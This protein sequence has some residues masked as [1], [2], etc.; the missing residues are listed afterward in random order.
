MTPNIEAAIIGLPSPG[1]VTGF[2][3]MPTSALAAFTRIPVR[4]VFSPAMSTT[5][6]IIVTSTGPKYLAVSPDAAVETISLGTPI[7]SRCIA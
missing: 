2:V 7:G 3:A 1:G 5:E 4:I 6:Y